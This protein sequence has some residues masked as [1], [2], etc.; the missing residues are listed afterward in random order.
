VNHTKLI[1][2]RSPLVVAA[3]CPDCGN[4]QT[5]YE[6]MVLFY[7][8]DKCQSPFLPYKTPFTAYRKE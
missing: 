5:I 8:C 6:Q 7:W 3:V 4:I 2:Y 1:R